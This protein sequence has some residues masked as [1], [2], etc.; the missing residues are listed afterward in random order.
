MQEG[1]IPLPRNQSGNFL[2]Q[3]LLALTC[4]FAFMPFFASQLASRDMASQMYATTRQVDNATAAARIFIRE[5][6]SQ[7]PYEKT[8]VSGDRFSDLLEPYGLPLGFVPRTALGQDIALVINNDAGQVSAYLEISGGNLSQ[9]QL[10]ELARRIGFYATTGDGAL[11]VGI[12]LD[13]VYS[14]VV[15]RNVADLDSGFLTELDMGGFNLDNVGNIIARRG[16]FDTGEFTTLSLSGTESGRKVKNAIKNINADRVVFQSADG[17]AA[18]TLTRGVLSVGGVDAR[19]IAAYGDAGNFTATSAA[20]YDF[21]MT[22]GRTGFTGPRDWNVRGNVVTDKINFSVERLEINSFL[23]ASRGQDVYINTDTLE[24]SSNSGI[25]A[26]SIAA[27][28]ITMRDQT[29]DALA[30]GESG[31]V[32]LDIRPAGTSILPDVLLGKIN[33]DGIAPLANPSADDAATVACKTLISD[34]GGVYNQKSLSQYLVCQYY[35]WVRLE[36]R[37]DIK[38]CMLDGKS[39]CE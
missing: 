19:T 33:N 11:L 5:N 4:V 14:D 8:V 22:A 9:L 30:Q 23:N 12:E 17:A 25:S 3:A 26:S 35:Y 32:I 6:L 37:I 7:I 36:Q 34:L 16:E 15:R 27:S 29:S 10:S 31:A 13:N 20:A 39:G 28:N 2:L 24:Y 21:A 18:M 1:A 38:Q